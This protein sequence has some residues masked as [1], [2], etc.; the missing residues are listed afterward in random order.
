MRITL[1]RSR[2]ILDATGR[3]KPRGS[4]AFLTLFA[5]V[6]VCDL[7]PEPT[8]YAMFAAVRLCNFR[9]D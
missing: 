2:I 1:C 8:Y 4:G 9:P 5:T 6:R 7:P 3:Q